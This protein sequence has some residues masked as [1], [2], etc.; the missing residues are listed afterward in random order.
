MSNSCPYKPRKV[1]TEKQAKKQ[2]VG[3][4]YHPTETTFRSGACPEGF[5]LRKG[6]QKKSYERKDGIRIK[7]TYVDPICVKNKG[8]PGKLT[9]EASTIHMDE[10]HSYKPLGYKTTNNSKTRHNLLLDSVKELS[11]ATVLRKL[12]ALKLF[13][14]KENNTKNQE[15]SKII[16]TDIDMLKEWRKENPDLYK[17]K[18]I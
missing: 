10:E 13:H 1:L 11:Y 17:K 3:S 18:S 5:D 8:L 15:L 2:P 6:Y 16:G 4:F 14:S 9:R 12:S 7:G